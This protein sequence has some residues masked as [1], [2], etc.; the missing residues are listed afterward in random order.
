MRSRCRL[1]IAIP[2][3]NERASIT[4]ALNAFVDQ[5]NLD[6]TRLDPRSFEV[7]VLAN[8]CDDD[9]ESVARAFAALHSAYEI[10]VVSRRLP[11]NAAHVGSARRMALDL[12]VERQCLAHGDAGIV[13]TT[14]ADSIVDRFWVARTL[15]ELANVDA[16]AGCVEISDTERNAMEAPLRVL[17][18]RER[19]YRRAIGDVEARFDPRPFDPPSRH[20][21][22]VGASFAVRVAT[23]TAAGGSPIVPRLEDVAFARALR[24]IDARI[25]HSYDVRVS[26]SGRVNAR[27]DGGFGSFLDDLRT[28]GA[29]HESFPV[30]SGRRLVL[31]A[32]ARGSLRAYWAHP[33]DIKSLEASARTYNLTT[34]ALFEVVDPFAPFGETIDR[35]EALGIAFEALPDEPVEVALATL[36]DAT[37]T[38]PSFESRTNA[39]LGSA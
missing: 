5:R 32:K 30:E 27:V 38:L 28:R 6:G 35:V 34:R 39:T 3:K 33:A 16:V 13:G 14:D 2:A 21:S 20:D 31:R 12:A 22:F 18:D 7:I 23:Y 4:Q 1:S 17:Y 8:D 11:R 9:T 26:T 19:A 25:R 29:R 24:R 36:R 37:S 15:T 10:R